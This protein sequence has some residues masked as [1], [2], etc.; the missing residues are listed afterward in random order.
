MA[1]PRPLPPPEPHIPVLLA[2][3][4]KAIAP[5]QG[6][7]LDAT[8]GAGGYTRAL[9][10]AGAAEVVALD[11]DPSALALADP[12]APFYGAR[13]RRVEARFS[14]LAA[15]AGGPL[16]G[17]VF[18]LGVSSMQLD[19]PERGF[20]FQKDGPLDMRMEG[21]A[22]GQSAADLVNRL[23]EKALADLL[24]R[25]GEERESRRIARAIVAARASGP[26][27]RTRALAE[28][29]ARV[30]PR[31]KPH[32]PHPATRSFQ[33]LRIAVNGEFDE[34]AEGLMG[35]EAALAPGGLLAVVSFHSLE[36]RMVK[37]FLQARAGKAGGGSRYA[38][39]AQGAAPQFELLQSKA[40]AAS[41][42]ECAANPRARSAKL[43]LARR[44][45]APAGRLSPVLWAE[46]LG[47]PVW[48]EKE[49]G[50]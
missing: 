8:F 36:D 43:R 48:D 2:P 49:G 20:S 32:E 10:E 35:A 40:L 34:L 26:I 5:V 18:D 15:Q 38:P 45:A 25:F 33:A 7:W 27:T 17:V 1:E 44:T 21:A 50:R 13:L 6:R 22:G 16:Q 37:R 41:P 11:R 47:L 4:L 9:L 42:E 39:E 31:P 24:F 30:L 12:W 29:I 14:D 46:T 23:P 19:Q 3:L 28:V